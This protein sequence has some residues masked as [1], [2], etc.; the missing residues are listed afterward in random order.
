MVS[1]VKMVAAESVET[2]ATFYKTTSKDMEML[3]VTNQL[4]M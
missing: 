3:K 2:L 1:T 4:A